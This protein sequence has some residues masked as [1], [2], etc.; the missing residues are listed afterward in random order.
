MS[1]REQI[2]IERFVE[3]EGVT[4]PELENECR[5]TDLQDFAAKVSG[6]ECELIALRL[7][8]TNVE[9]EDIKI[10]NI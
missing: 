6:N 8:L 10:E 3:E 7:G 9:I 5:D 2:D 4:L 1:D